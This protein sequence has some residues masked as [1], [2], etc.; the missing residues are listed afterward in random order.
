[1][2][3]NILIGGANKPLPALC[4]AALKTNLKAFYNGCIFDMLTQKNLIFASNVVYL[5]Q[6]ML[7][8][9][10]HM[11]KNDEKHWKIIKK[12]LFIMRTIG[13]HKAHVEKGRK[14]CTFLMIFKCVSSF[15]ANAWSG[16][17]TQ[18]SRGENAKNVS[19]FSN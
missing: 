5:D 8:N 7:V 19:H 16:Q 11:I 14:I 3:K 18:H 6:Q 1:M 2:V 17:D 12:Y 10:I 4:T 15:N 9:A 13:S